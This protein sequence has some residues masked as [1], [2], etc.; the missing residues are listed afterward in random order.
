LARPSYKEIAQF[1]LDLDLLNE[2]ATLIAEKMK[3]ADGNFSRYIGGS[4][5]I[6]KKFLQRFYEEFED[7]LKDIKDRFP[8]YPKP[9]NI[10]QGITT[11][12][13]NFESRMTNRID[14]LEQNQA[15]MF[16]ESLRQIERLILP[17]INKA[18]KEVFEQTIDYAIKKH[19]ENKA[20]EKTL[21]KKTTK[22]SP[23]KKRKP[24]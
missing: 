7:K 18:D 16:G 23:P 22:R 10:P 5:P 1:Y 15:Q 12:L 9:D 3:M 8:Q 17:L 2:D 24:K 20:L 21:N 4:I 13:T 11:L 6:T 19:F 14:K